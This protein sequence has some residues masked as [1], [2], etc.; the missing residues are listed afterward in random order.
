MLKNQ[1]E[2][3]HGPSM[4]LSVAIRESRISDA[5][6]TVPVAFSVCC[7]V[8][9]SDAMRSVLLAVDTRDHHCGLCCCVSSF[10]YFVLV[11]IFSWH[12]LSVLHGIVLVN[13]L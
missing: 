9:F 3:Y 8:F 12:Y 4:G 5:N 6:K 10:P 1:L 11:L 2:N 7:M 13:S